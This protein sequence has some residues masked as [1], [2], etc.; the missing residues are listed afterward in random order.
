[1]FTVGST[2]DECTTH[3]WSN[4]LFLSSQLNVAIFNSVLLAQG[5]SL[6][7]SLRFFLSLGP[8]QP[9]V[10][11]PDGLTHGGI[12]SFL[13]LSKIGRVYEDRQQRLCTIVNLIIF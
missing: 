6:P 3:C 5:S 7:S 12:G 1:V 9:K 10:H 2:R 4:D 8:N 13:C 11:G